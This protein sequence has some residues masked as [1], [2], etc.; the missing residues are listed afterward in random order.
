MAAG[1]ADTLAAADDAR[2]ADALEAGRRGD[3]SRGTRTTRRTQVS[4]RC[5]GDSQRG[6]KHQEVGA[7]D[8]ASVDLRPLSTCASGFGASCLIA[9]HPLAVRVKLTSPRKDSGLGSVGKQQT[10]TIEDGCFVL[11]R[12]KAAKSTRKQT[13]PCTRSYRPKC[14]PDFF[15]VTDRH[16]SPNLIGSDFRRKSFPRTENHGDLIT[17]EQKVLNGRRESRN[18]HRYAAVVQ[19]LATQWNP[20]QTKTSLE[21]DKNLRK[22]ALTIAEAK[23]YSYSFFLQF[24]KHCAELSWNYRTTTLHRSETSGLAE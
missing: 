4:G 19:V 12:R 17:A 13:Y 6:S 7:A 11:L 2:A 1:E 9:A 21:T 10:R 16:P 3:P 23:S 5:S 24:G 18:N 8:G 22:L 15:S 14:G 20:C